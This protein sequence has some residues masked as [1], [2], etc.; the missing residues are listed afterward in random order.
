MLHRIHN[1]LLDGFMFSLEMCFW[2]VRTVL[3]LVRIGADQ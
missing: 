2:S 1:Y 3:D